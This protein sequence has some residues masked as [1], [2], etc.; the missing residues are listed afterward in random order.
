LS[1]ILHERARAGALSRSRAPDDPDLVAA[2]QN[3]EAL[4]L[5]KYVIAQASILRPEQREHIAKLLRA[6]GGAT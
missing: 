2:R 4:Q 6:V 1:P 3:L 5:E